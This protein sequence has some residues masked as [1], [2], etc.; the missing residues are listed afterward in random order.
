MVY[1]TNYNSPIG[2]LTLV[3]DGEKLI[4][5]EIGNCCR[6]MVKKDDLIV[7][8]IIINWLDN[9]FKGEKLDLLNLPLLIKGTEFQKEVWKIVSEI[10]YGELISYGDIAKR[11]AKERGIKR[12]SSQAVGSAVGCNPI[13]III[14]CHRVVG[15]GNLGGYASGISIK[16]ELLKLEGINIDCFLDQKNNGLD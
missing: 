11:I 13:A 12:M 6:E 7:F 14:P 2:L 8:K 3:S 16:K 15:T 4:R 1:T 10:P 9:Y 5:L